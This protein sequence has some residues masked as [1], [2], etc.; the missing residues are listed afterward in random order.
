MKIIVKYFIII[1]LLKST[2]LFCQV[3]SLKHEIFL[4]DSIKINIDNYSN[5]IIFDEE[6]K[7]IRKNK[8]NINMK[9][10]K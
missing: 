9:S 1:F 4:N 5:D 3:D 10:S 6:Y 8:T 7:K 2:N